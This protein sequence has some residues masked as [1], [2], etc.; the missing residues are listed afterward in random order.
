MDAQIESFIEL[1]LTRG[2]KILLAHSM[3]WSTKRR[4]V[5]AVLARIS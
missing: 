1:F 2:G 5:K 4:E 3:T